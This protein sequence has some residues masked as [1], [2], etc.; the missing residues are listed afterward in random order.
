MVRLCESAPP[1]VVYRFMLNNKERYPLTEMT[2]LFRVSRSAYYRWVKQ[3]ISERREKADA[4]LVEQLRA[5]QKDHHQRGR[6][7][8]RRNCGGVTGSG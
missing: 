8:Y 3:G 2:S 4:A 6:R 1:V 5:I 7:G